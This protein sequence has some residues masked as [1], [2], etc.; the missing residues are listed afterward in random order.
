MPARTA[1]RLPTRGCD[2][3]EPRR[4]RRGDHGDSSGG[5]GFE[6]IDSATVGLLDGDGDT[7]DGEHGTT[8]VDLELNCG[9]NGI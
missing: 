3:G 2:G 9:E 1:G 7:F 6:L 8:V 4:T 5:N